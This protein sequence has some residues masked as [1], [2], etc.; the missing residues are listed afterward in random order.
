MKVT[1]KIKKEFDAKFIKV[2]AGVRY[3]QDA[4]VNGND[5]IDFTETNGI[6]APAIPCA[7]RV[8]EEPQEHLLSD[9]YRWQPVI[10]IEE[11]RILDWPKGVTA[12]VH[13]KIC[14]NGTYEILDAEKNVIASADSYV[15]DVLCPAEEGY[16]DYII[17]TVLEDGTIEDWKCDED[18]LIGIVKG[19]FDYEDD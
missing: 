9:H 16:G 10:D 15:P 5:D 2:D 14:D 1:L 7:V 19:D 13:Y 18:L 12:N 8:K 11:G 3:W 6:G 17:M 4:E